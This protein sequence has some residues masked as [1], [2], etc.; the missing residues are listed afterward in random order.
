MPTTEV[1]FW[2]EHLQQVQKN[3]RRGVAK[4]AA[5]RRRKRQQTCT[6]E[7]PTAESS[8]SVCCAVRGEL[9]EDYTDEVE[10]WIGCDGCFKWLHY[11]SAGITVEPDKYLCYQCQ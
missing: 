4:A 5:T 11:N 1:S 9:Y 7:Y 8:T 6:Y 2:I 10:K 3:R